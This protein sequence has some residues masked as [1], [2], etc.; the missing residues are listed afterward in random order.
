MRMLRAE[1][2][3][4]TREVEYGTP[5]QNETVR[6][7]VEDVRTEG[8]AALLRYTEEHDRV[9]LDAQSLRV[10]E[11]E[12][13]AAYDLVDEAFL[14]AIRQAAVNIRSFHE[15]QVRQSWMDVQPD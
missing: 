15:K 5:E 12:I 9:R 13:H 10:T 14:T 7:I 2:Y 3:G 6:Q 1:Q 4:L 11:A 8:D